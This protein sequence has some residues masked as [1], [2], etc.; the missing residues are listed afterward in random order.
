MMRHPFTQ[1]ILKLTY[2]KKERDQFLDD[3][4]QY[5]KKFKRLKKD[6]REAL[7]SKNV[8][9]INNEIVK[10]HLNPGGDLTSAVIHLNYPVHP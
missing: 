3:P 9:R 7:L 2:D 4:K 6:Q 5:L 1:L 8:N 10:E